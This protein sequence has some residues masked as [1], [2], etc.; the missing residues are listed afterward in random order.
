MVSTEYQRRLHS[1]RA[2]SRR[3]RRAHRLSSQQRQA[4]IHEVSAAVN[5]RHG[6]L[7]Q[8]NE[9]F[10]DEQCSDSACQRCEALFRQETVLLFRRYDFG[11]TMSG[12]GVA[13]GA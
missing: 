13:D 11:L 3:S 10:C 9:G 7:L 5:G 1:L 4:A 6:S 2:V 8:M 12:R